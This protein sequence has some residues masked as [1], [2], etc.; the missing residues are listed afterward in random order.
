MALILE[1]RA[2]LL[3]QRGEQRGTV[4]KWELMTHSRLERGPGY[5]TTTALV[6][7]GFCD[8][9]DQILEKQEL[10]DYLEKMRYTM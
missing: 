10:E 3:Q 8:T 5:Y 1:R 7:G 4:P 6:G 9:H 2:R